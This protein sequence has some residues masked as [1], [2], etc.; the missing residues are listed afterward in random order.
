M[1]VNLVL[2]SFLSNLIETVELVEVHAV[3]VR[4]QQTV[5]SDSYPALLANPGTAN[6]A[7]LAQHNR[8]VGNENVLMIVR[9]DGIR[10]EHLHRPHRVAVKPIHQYRV[11]RQSFVDHIRLAHGIVDVGLRR[12]LVIGCWYLIAA[13]PLFTC[14]SGSSHGGWL[15]RLQQR[16]VW[17]L[18]RY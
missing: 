9:V 14:G 3:S 18:C 17:V 4:H 8:S 11:E 7:S 6:L 5:E 1:V 15:A 16:G 10:Y 13:R 12:S 2:Q